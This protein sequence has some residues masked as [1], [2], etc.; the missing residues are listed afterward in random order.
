M[1]NSGWIHNRVGMQY[2]M[3]EKDV[4]NNL[5]IRV[6]MGTRLGIIGCVT[7]ACS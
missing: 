2:E 1:G 4:E 5:G 3:Q 7:K 6:E